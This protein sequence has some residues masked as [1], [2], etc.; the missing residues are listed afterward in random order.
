MSQ[1][2]WQMSRRDMTSPRPKP[3]QM[4]R[5][6][7]MSPNFLIT[8]GS[9][10]VSGVKKSGPKRKELCFSP[11]STRSAGK[12]SKNS[13][14]IVGHDPSFEAKMS[15]FGGLLAHV[16]CTSPTLWQKCRDMS[17]HVSGASRFLGKC[18]DMS[19]TWPHRDFRQMSKRMS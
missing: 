7:A 1:G 2:L 8:E 3:W 18:R 14:K 12:S 11:K 19:K 9:D 5:Y 6:I 10:R 4:S 15:P 17:R 13:L 16:T